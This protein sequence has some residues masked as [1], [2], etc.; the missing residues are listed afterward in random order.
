MTFKVNKIPEKEL[1]VTEEGS[2]IFTYHYGG[3]SSLPYFHPVYAP[4]GEVVTADEDVGQQY[5]PGLCFTLGTIAAS[6]EDSEQTYQAFMRRRDIVTPKPKAEFLKF[7]LLSQW[8]LPEASAHLVPPSDVARF[9]SLAFIFSELLMV[10]VYPLQETELRSSDTVNIE[11]VSP[12]RSKNPSVRVFDVHVG[13]FGTPVNLTFD[14]STGLSYHA[15]AMEYPKVVDSEG[16]I[17]AAEANGGMAK[18]CTLGGIVANDAIGV[19]ILPH[20]KN[21]E[22]RFF[23]EE[24]ALGFL[25]AQTPSFTLKAEASLTLRY[26]VLVYV[27]DLFTVDVSDYYQDYIKA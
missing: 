25:K 12:S 3:I 22:T 11:N 24:T 19:A 20:P 23:A 27:G 7:D 1:S 21:G 2:P 14:G 13:L 17:G 8:K 15:V 9:G 26:R 10:R 16:R 6:S 5:P 4:N 18:W